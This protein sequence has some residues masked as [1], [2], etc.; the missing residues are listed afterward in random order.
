MV[1]M[2]REKDSAELLLHPVQQNELTGVCLNFI[3]KNNFEDHLEK[4]DLVSAF[5]FGKNNRLCAKDNKLCLLKYR[6]V[7]AL[8]NKDSSTLRAFSS[9]CTEYPTTAE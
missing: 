7:V 4:R 6:F 2:Y 8:R 5:G 1:Y 3:L 9:P